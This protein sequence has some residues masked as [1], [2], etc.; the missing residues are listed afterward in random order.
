MKKITKYTLAIVIISVGQL[1][2]FT[3]SILSGIFIVL[4]GF[5]I[6][7]P[8]ADD[9][10]KEMKKMKKESDKDLKIKF[11]NKVEK[12][13]GRVFII[14]LLLVGIFLNNPSEDN[15]EKDTLNKITL[16]SEEDRQ[17]VVHRY[18]KISKKQQPYQISAY[19]LYADYQE[20][21][22]AAD[23]KYK[24]KKLAVT[25]VIEDIG[26]NI[27]D[28]IYITLETGKAFRN[29][30]CH[31]NKKVAARLRR[32]QQVTVIGRCD[33]LSFNVILEKCELWEEYQEEYQ[34]LG[35]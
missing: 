33:G 21:D 34:L 28:D 4:S 18:Y 31:I 23:Y 22:I 35:H 25:G 20:N 27:L 13:T 12:I 5:F 17:V 2:I 11:R 19:Q 15:T 16:A 29:I 32:G 6:L 7:P 1:Q 30:K 3:G 10:R 24:G 26:T 8:I 9:I 14:G